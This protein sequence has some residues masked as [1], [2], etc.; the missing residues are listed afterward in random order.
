MKRIVSLFV[1]FVVICDVVICDDIIDRIIAEVN[2]NVNKW[3]AGVNRRFYDASEEYINSQMGAFLDEFDSIED[4]GIWP[5]V[6]LESLPDSYD[7]RDEYKACK[8][9]TEIRD[10]GSCGSCWVS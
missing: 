5:Q 4:R 9:V 8:S 10:Q 6:E 2:N 1:I 7:V 3:T